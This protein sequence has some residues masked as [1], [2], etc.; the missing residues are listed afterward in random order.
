M[1]LVKYNL[2]LG[3][4]GVDETEKVV[5]EEEIDMKFLDEI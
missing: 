2:T 5:K 4:Y 3:F 1:C